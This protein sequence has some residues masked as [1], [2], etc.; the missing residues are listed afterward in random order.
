[1]QNA[2]L[3]EIVL[4]C[5]DSIRYWSSILSHVLKRNWNILILLRY[6]IEILKRCFHVICFNRLCKLKGTTDT[7]RLWCYLA[8]LLTRKSSRI[9]LE[10]FASRLFQYRKGTFSTAVEF[11]RGN[12]HGGLYVTSFYFSLI[13]LLSHSFTYTY[14]N[15]T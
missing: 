14:R 3:M 4:R 8:K 11:Y 1:M 6:K 12:D 10:Q 7:A 13:V 2:Q 15:S 5:H 9:F